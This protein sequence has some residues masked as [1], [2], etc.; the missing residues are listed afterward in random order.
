MV[1][2]E[3]TVLSG[4]T[5]LRRLQDLQPYG[6]FGLSEPRNSGPTALRNFVFPNLGQSTRCLY[7]RNLVPYTFDLKAW[8]ES[9]DTGHINF[10]LMCN[11]R[12]SQQVRSRDFT[13]DTIGSCTF[14]VR[15]PPLFLGM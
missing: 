15:K 4:P 1:P 5:I 3:P 2:T 14:A 12:Y 8:P 6:T 11:F 7:A 9:H 10:P 13:A